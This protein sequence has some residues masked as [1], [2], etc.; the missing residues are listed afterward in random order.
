MLNANVPKRD[1]DFDTCQH[2]PAQNVAYDNNGIYS[3]PSHG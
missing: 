3:L 1:Y 2:L